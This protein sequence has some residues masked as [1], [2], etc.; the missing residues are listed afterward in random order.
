MKVRDTF[1]IWVTEHAKWRMLL[2]DSQEMAAIENNLAPVEK[3]VEASKIIAAAV[4]HSAANPRYHTGQYNRMRYRMY[5]L[6]RLARVLEAAAEQTDSIKEALLAIA[7]TW[8]PFYHRVNIEDDLP[9][10]NINHQRVL[11]GKPLFQPLKPS[12]SLVME[13]GGMSP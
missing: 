10:Y 8:Q 9:L 6:N 4:Q 11:Q 3:V 13:F 1:A 12:E 5:I 7:D 2:H